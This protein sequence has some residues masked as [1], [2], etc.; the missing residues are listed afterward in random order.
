M[1]FRSVYFDPEFQETLDRLRDKNPTYHD[2]VIKKI[3]DIREKLEW[4]PDHHKNLEK[5]LQIFKRVHVNT[6]Y[7]IVFRVNK[8][9]KKLLIVD[10]DHHDN[11]YKKK[12]LLNY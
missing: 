1:L 6:S 2:N 3:Q 9:Q 12:R 4:N 5:P 8:S 7:V 10:Y 11:I